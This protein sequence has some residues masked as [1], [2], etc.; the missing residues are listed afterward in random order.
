MRPCKPV[1]QRRSQ[2]VMCTKQ[3]RNSQ[4]ATVFCLIV[5]AF[6]FSLGIPSTFICFFLQYILQPSPTWRKYYCCI[7][8]RTVLFCISFTSLLQ[9]IFCK[10]GTVHEERKRLVCTFIS[11]FNL[12][13]FNCYCQRTTWKMVKFT[14][15][16]ATSTG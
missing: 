16:L 14:L 11:S 1:Q 2:C 9:W 5:V 10:F 6:C 3:S 7:V 13:I 15:L 12:A 8:C 4:F